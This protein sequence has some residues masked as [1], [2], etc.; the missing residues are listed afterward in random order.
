MVDS[1]HQYL[2]QIP[3]LN[4]IA[5]LALKMEKRSL[6]ASLAQRGG[7]SHVHFL[8]GKLTRAILFVSMV[9]A[10]GI[11]CCRMTERLAATLKMLT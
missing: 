11:V 6:R 5:M 2:V 9:Q 4:T 8:K 7:I 3:W 10:K 1:P